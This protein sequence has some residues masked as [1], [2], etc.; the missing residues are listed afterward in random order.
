M[1]QTSREKDMVAYRYHPDSRE[2]IREIVPVPIP[3]SDEVLI[4]VLAAGVCHSDLGILT[5]DIAPAT[6][7]H[8]FTLGH[9]GAGIIVELGS[10]VPDTHPELKL[11][12]YVAIHSCNPC[13][14]ETCPLCSSGRDNVCMAKHSYGF[15]ADGSWAAYCAVRAEMAIPVPGDMKSVPP[16]IAAIA[17]DAILSPYH[18]LKQSIGLKPEQTLLVI[19]CGGLGISTIQIAKNWLGA[20]RV[21]GCDVRDLGLEAAKLAGADDTV[22]PGD[23]L[24]FVEKSALHIDAVIDFVGTNNSFETALGAVGFGG[25]IQVVGMGAKGVVVP[26]LAVAI[27]DVTVKASYW[28]RREELVEVLEAISQGKIKTEV[29]IRRLEEANQALK[30]MVAGKLRA[31]VVLVP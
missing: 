18:A 16:A 24:E 17:T 12:T 19:G 8:V 26:F 4:K 9:E 30:D 23:L 6:W 2:P 20:K 14:N 27:K 29:E 3:A 28:G 10:Y 11:G 31:R 25:I 5:P 22:K 21:V 7:P 15:G 1:E 13:L